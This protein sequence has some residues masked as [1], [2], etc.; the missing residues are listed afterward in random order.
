VKT[1]MGERLIWLVSKKKHYGSTTSEKL[2]Y[3]NFRLV[4]EENHNDR[5]FVLIYGL[6]NDPIKSSDNTVE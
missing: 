2:V 6:F 3:Q 5:E 1:V 4:T